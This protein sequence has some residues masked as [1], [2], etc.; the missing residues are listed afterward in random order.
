MQNIQ[1][2]ENLI[3]VMTKPVSIDIFR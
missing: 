2:N 3:H 1:I